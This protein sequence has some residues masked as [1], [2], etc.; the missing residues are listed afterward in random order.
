MSGNQGKAE[1]VGGRKWLEAYTREIEWGE[2][3]QWRLERLV[4]ITLE[5][6]TFFASEKK[7]LI[8]KTQLKRIDQVRRQMPRDIFSTRLIEMMEK[9]LD[10]QE[11]DLY[12]DLLPLDRFNFLNQN[13]PIIR[14]KSKWKPSWSKEFLLRLRQEFRKLPDHAKRLKTPLGRSLISGSKKAKGECWK[15]S[16][17]AKKYILQVHDLFIDFYPITRHGLSIM[18]L[19]EEGGL[20]PD[21]FMKDIAEFFQQEFPKQFGDLTSQDVIARIQ[22]AHKSK[23]KRPNPRSDEEAIAERS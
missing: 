6:E 5:L 19:T 12:Q 22:Y 2:P 23:F 8:P 1:T 9:E 16:A 14:S 11:I 15:S 10:T 18:K 17:I 21:A 13:F 4:L 20:Y 7:N 3:H